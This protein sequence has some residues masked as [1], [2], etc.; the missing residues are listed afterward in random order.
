[1]SATDRQTD[2]EKKTK[3]DPLLITQI[4]FTLLDFQFIFRVLSHKE[5]KCSLNQEFINTCIFKNH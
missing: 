1:M 2:R 3:H 5:I 4:D